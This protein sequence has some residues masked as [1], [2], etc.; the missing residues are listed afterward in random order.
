M[1]FRFICYKGTCSSWSCVSLFLLCSFGYLFLPCH[2]HIPIFKNWIKCFSLTKHWLSLTHLGHTFCD[3]Q[4]LRWFLIGSTSWRSCPFCIILALSDQDLVTQRMYHNWCHVASETKSPKEC[5][6]SRS[7]LLSFL[8][9]H[10]FRKQLAVF[11]AS[12]RRGL[13]G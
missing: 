1:S 11:I 10:S 9:P 5:L 13:Y 3:R 2:F 7:F 4:P 8:N 12:Y 6:P